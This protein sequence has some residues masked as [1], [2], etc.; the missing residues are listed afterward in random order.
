M[1]ASVHLDWSD[2]QPPGD[3][4][5]YPMA[6]AVH[7][8]PETMETT[9]MYY[10]MKPVWSTQLLVKNFFQ[11]DTKSWQQSTHNGSCR[12]TG[13]IVSELVPDW[14]WVQF[15]IIHSLQLS[16]IMYLHCEGQHWAQCANWEHPA[17]PSCLHPSVVREVYIFHSCFKSCWLH[18]STQGH[19]PPF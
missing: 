14:F 17:C 13:R 9:L 19:Y 5:Q 11:S 3:Q 8:L 16:G 12:V 1:W 2:Y 15:F 4:Q 7:H 18:R 10:L 6:P